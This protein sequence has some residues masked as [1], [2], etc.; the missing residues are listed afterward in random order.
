MAK[1]LPCPG[2]CGYVIEEVDIESALS[3]L[4]MHKDLEETGKCIESIE[5]GKIARKKVGETEAKVSVVK[6]EETHKLKVCRNCNRTGKEGHFKA[7]CKS[8]KRQA[9]ANKIT[10]EVAGTNVVKADVARTEAD[11]NLGI[12]AGLMMTVAN[13]HKV[14]TMQG[15]K[16]MKVPH[17]LYE[18]IKWVKKSPQKHPTCTLSVTVSVKGYQEVDHTP[19]PATRRRDTDMSA[20]TD[21][22][23]QVFCMG[24]TQLHA[25]GLTRRDLLEPGL[26][27]TAVSSRS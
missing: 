20:L 15:H 21:T 23:C 26:S 8:A 2:Q 1:S 27:L 16:R 24:P 18:Q 25:L 12:V 17:M 11:C 10:E 3:L 19:P 5:S 9:E 6:T 14:K 4:T 13:V 7:C 22:G